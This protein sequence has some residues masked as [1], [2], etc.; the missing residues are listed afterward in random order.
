MAMAFVQTY[1]CLG[2]AIGRIG[3]SLIL[4]TSMLAPV[5]MLGNREISRYQTFFLISGVMLFILLF[6]LPTLPSFIP[7]HDDYYEPKR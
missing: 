1:S 6:L 3:T 4:G 5:W 7:K 2:G